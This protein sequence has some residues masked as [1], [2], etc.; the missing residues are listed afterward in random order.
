VISGLKRGAL[1]RR[2]GLHGGRRR[3]FLLLLTPSFAS[4]LPD[5]HRPFTFSSFSRYSSSS[6][7]SRARA[8]SIP[9]AILASRSSRT[10][11]LADYVAAWVCMEDDGVG[12]FFF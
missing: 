5:D 4:V 7:I 1:C 2:L 6:S 11:Q 12:F 10:L 8:G 3:R 9:F